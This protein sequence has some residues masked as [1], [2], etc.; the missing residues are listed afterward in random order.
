MKRFCLILS[1]LMVFA[2]V[3]SGCSKTEEIEKNEKTEVTL[4][5]PDGEFMYLEK[6]IREIEA[7]ERI[8]KSVLLEVFKGPDDENLLPSVSG[9][10]TVLSVKTENGLCT[11]D[12]SSEFAE[13][14]TGGSAKESMAIMSIVKSL[15]EIDGIE[16]VKINIEGNENPDFWGHFTLEDPFSPDGI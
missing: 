6:E 8:E 7:G 10:I 16:K 5:F 12:L 3:L 9:D 11:V 4:Y 13:H 1:L 2:L 14:N 15:C